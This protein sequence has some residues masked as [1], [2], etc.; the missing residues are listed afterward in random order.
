M[1]V[2]QRNW[3][4]VALI[5]ACSLLAAL[6]FVLAQEQPAAT[7]K[8]A[9]PVESMAETSV[10]EE[11]IAKQSADTPR[12]SSLPPDL[13]AIHQQQ[14]PLKGSTL[15]GENLDHE[16]AA[17]FARVAAEETAAALPSSLPLPIQI[18]DEVVMIGAH[19]DSW[20]SG[21]GATDNGVSSAVMMEAMR[22]LKATGLKPRRTIRMGLWT[23]EEQ[24]LLGARAYVKAHFADRFDIKPTAEHAKLAAY[25]NMDNGG[26]AYRGVYLQGN[27][28]VVP[29]FTAWMKPFDNLGMTTPYLSASAIMFGAVAVAVA[30][31]RSAP[32]H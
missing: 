1:A 28:A 19:F 32:A 16:R 23:G 5:S 10:S 18:A 21:T 9:V 11:P 24:G 29:I 30:S 31:L 27:E 7:S 6:G 15:G 25:F 3:R 26:G 4:L 14:N 8:A 2:F 17:A 22:I 20:H 13:G 12:L